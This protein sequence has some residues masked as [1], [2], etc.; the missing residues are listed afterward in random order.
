MFTLYT[1][2]RWFPLWDENAAVIFAWILHP[3]FTDAIFYQ[4]LV[5]QHRHLW[6][7]ELGSSESVQKLLVTFTL[8]CSCSF[9]KYSRFFF[10]L[11]ISIVLFTWYCEKISQLNII[12]MHVPS[13]CRHY[14]IDI[15]KDIFRYL[16]AIKN[17]F[18]ENTGKKC[19]LPHQEEPENS[20][21]YCL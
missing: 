4:A 15:M 14:F 21:K 18:W 11:L 1:A 6:L 5:T 17:I 16:K 12:V 13:A 20:W 2:H 19:I 8:V 3:S 9:E 10:L 7:V